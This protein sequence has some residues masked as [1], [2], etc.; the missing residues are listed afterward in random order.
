MYKSESEILPTFEAKHLFYLTNTKGMLN[1]EPKSC[2]AC[3]PKSTDRFVRINSSQAQS[4]CGTS[5]EIVF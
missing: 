5:L 1:E 4:Y 3:L 2:F